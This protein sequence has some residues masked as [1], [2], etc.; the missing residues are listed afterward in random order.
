MKIIIIALFFLCMA[1]V[2]FDDKCKSYNFDRG[3]ILTLE[4]VFCERTVH[5][6]DEVPYLPLEGARRQFEY[7]G[8]PDPRY[9]TPTPVSEDA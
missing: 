9:Q 6:S 3:A 4:G 8:Q 1:Q 2:V 5:G 7:S